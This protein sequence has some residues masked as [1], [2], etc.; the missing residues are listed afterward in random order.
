ML[1]YTL[2]Y[3]ELC[4]KFS[5]LSKL[6]CNTAVVWSPYLNYQIQ[7]LDNIQTRFLRFLVLKCNLSREQH[8]PYQPLLDFFF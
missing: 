2:Q 3:E 6:E 8:S 5:I 4:I 7:C 1:Q